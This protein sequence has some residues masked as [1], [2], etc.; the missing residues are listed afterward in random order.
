MYGL[1]ESPDSDAIIDP[2]M[3]IDRVALLL[4][5][6]RA[7]AVSDGQGV[8]WSSP[9]GGSG[10]PVRRDRPSGP[11]FCAAAAR[12]IDSGAAHYLQTRAVAAVPE[13]ATAYSHSSE[14]FSV[15][16]FGASRG[17]LDVAWADLASHY[18]GLCLSIETDQR[19]ERI[20]EAWPA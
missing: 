6:Q 3:P 8:R 18:R 19:P 20:S 4:D 13:V 12:L 7:G 5:Q 11:E 14:N 2:L 15:L 1:A 10:G 17:R 16:A 9:T